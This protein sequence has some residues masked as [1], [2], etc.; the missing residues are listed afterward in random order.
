M[1]L[2]T[3]A[4]ASDGSPP[5]V[6]AFRGFRE[7]V[8]SAGWPCGDIGYHGVRVLPLVS[9]CIGIVDSIRSSGRALC[10]SGRTR[11]LLI[12]DVVATHVKCRFRLY[13]HLWI[14]G[15]SC[16]GNGRRSFG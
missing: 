10:G 2:S 5:R 15:V 11:V 3:K 6:G 14:D 7:A 9:A 1:Q 4:L 16:V 13:L 8:F 12:S